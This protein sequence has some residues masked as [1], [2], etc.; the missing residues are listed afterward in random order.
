MAVAEWAGWEHQSGDNMVVAS[1]VLCIILI[2][3]S[4]LDTVESKKA[5]LT[6][7]NSDLQ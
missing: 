1:L 6:R 3:F 4:A 2:L 7:P 5:V